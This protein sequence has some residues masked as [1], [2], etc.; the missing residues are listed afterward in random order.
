LDEPPFYWSGLTREE[1]RK[2][3]AEVK[4]SLVGITSMF[5]MHSKG[6]H[7]VAKI[8]KEMFPK[9][10]VVLGGS[11]PSALPDWVLQDENI[12]IVVI[13][14]GELTLLEIIEKHEAEEDIFSISGTAVRR[15]GK[16]VLNIERPFIENL[17][18]LPFPARDM[19]DMSAYLY[20][21]Y[22]TQFAMKPPR[23]NIMT[24]RGC[25]GRCVFCSIHSIWRHRCRMFSAQRTVDEIDILVKK[26]GAREIAFLDDDL[27]C[28]KN[29]MKEI[30]REIIRR[31][32]NIKWCTPNGVAIW[33]LDE[34]L[35]DLMKASGLYKITFGIDTA[36][37]RTQKFI[38]KTHLDLDK[39]KKVVE[40]CNRIGM[41][42]HASF[43]IGFPYETK[44]DIEETINYAIESELDF[45]AFFI[46]TP[47]PGTPLYEIYKEE[48]LFPDFGNGRAMKWEG[49]QQ[50]VMT[51]T[52]H[53]KKEELQDYLRKAHQRFYHSRIK[54]FL[55]PL[56]I[57]RKIRGR[58]ELRYFLKL[59]KIARG[60]LN[61]VT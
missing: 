9:A 56:R 28:S 32:L 4:P 26:Y 30:C 41:W 34:E 14:E 57:F 49:S 17:D 19:L 45:A 2:K 25:T 7:D 6:A 39:A 29:R 52:H 36:S 31:N 38:H 11:H 21:P 16:V 35:L 40:Y 5:T 20:E 47:F 1:I 33:K 59:L 8:I 15:N 46:A 61:R 24:T 44:E 13:G 50:V 18:F 48:G 51:D 10:L 3:L 37:K 53:F 43:I 12:D 60:E 58:Y 23:L 42:T 22:R 54:K 55:N 27:V